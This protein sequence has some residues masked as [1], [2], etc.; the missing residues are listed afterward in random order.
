MST[1]AIVA[2]RAFLPV[3]VVW[4]P[5]ASFAVGALLGGVLA[6][7]AV[8]FASRPLRR[9]SPDVHWT[10]RARLV[11]PVRRSLALALM[12]G[13]I[14]SGPLTVGG[15]L[16][17]P[18]ALGRWIVGPVVALVAV[19][20]VA[21]AFENRFVRRLPPLTRWRSAA[22]YALLVAPAYWISGAFAIWATQDRLSLV[23]SLAAGAA[24]VALA[25]G[26]APWLGRAIRLSPP[27]PPRLRESLSRALHRVG[28]KRPRLVV[29]PIASANAFA[30]Q[31]TRTIGIT[32]GALARLDDTEL[33]AVIAHELGHLREPPG[34]VALRVALAVFLPVSL[35]IFPWVLELESGFGWL[36]L[37]LFAAGVLLAYRRLQRAL[38]KRADAV[39]QGASPGY[40]AALEKLYRVNLAPGALRRTA[41]HPDLFDRMVAAGATPSWPRPRP[42]PSMIPHLI[43]L[44][45]LGGAAFGATLY[46]RSAIGRSHLDDRSR[47]TLG[48]A[49]DGTAQDTGS[50]AHWHLQNHDENGAL[51]LFRAAEVMDVNEASWPAWVATVLS[52][53]GRCDEAAEALSRALSR[54]PASPHAVAA[55]SVLATCTPP[56]R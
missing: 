52:Y 17:R 44:V 38:E 9:L 13:L 7:A 6:A 39:A 3:W 2:A 4:S 20:A 26:A 41:T 30:F 33:D 31:L 45:T 29:L 43:V 5:V 18:G 49:I 56:S 42:P 22:A 51:A 8:A 37:W 53:Q 40:A 12:V 14:A 54:D 46:A 50:L 15:P 25:V 16:S 27:A 35:V 21:F 19:L 55:R 1:D 48:M 47:L 36:A 34:V 28:G 24:V 11:F 10:E 32:Q 23:W